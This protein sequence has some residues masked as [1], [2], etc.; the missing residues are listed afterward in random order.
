VNS[1]RL[2]YSPYVQALLREDPLVLIDVG[3]RNGEE[4]PWA[5]FPEDTIRVLGFE[6][7]DEECRRLAGRQLPGRRYLPVALWS[8]EGNV[9]VHVA[10]RPTSSSV[11]PP[12]D[13]VLRRYHPTHRAPRLTESVVRYP[14]TTLDHALQ[15]HGWSCDFLKIDT[16]G[17]EHEVLE[18]AAEA[19]DGP[20][21]GVLVETWTTEVH[22]GQRLTGD[23][24]SLLAAHGFE[25]FDVNVAAAWSR[26]VA[27]EPLDGRVQVV[28]LDLLL[29]KHPSRTTAPSAATALKGAVVADAFGF[30]D[31]A[32]EL[33]QFGTSLDPRLAQLEH[34]VRETGRRRAGLGAF[35]R[36][37]RRLRP[38]TADF[39]SLHD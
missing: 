1:Q 27:D 21:W 12:N 20:A 8:E 24:L 28:G 4:L 31:Y 36:L 29:F 33:L 25:V 35:D 3:A 5:A 16:Q 11:Y 34:Q 10:A 19:L 15:S 13:E 9:D 30:L 6:P 26:A 32:V 23:V 22:A 14:A 18:G 37:R 39:A 38:P 17:A 2:V 7:D